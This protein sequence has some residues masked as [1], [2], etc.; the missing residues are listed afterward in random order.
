MFVEPEGATPLDPD[1]MEGLKFKH[2]STRDD[3][4]EIEQANIVQGLRWLALQRG[5]NI[6]KSDF[7]CK[8]HTQLFG[9]I[10]NWAGS[11]RLTEKNIGI[12]PV[13][14]S[15][16]LRQLLDDARY[17]AENNTYAPL[18]A[19]ARFHHRMVQIHPFPNGN[20]RHARISADVYL[21]QYFN[22]API[23]WANGFN[24]QSNNNRRADY[25]AALRTADAGN[26]DLLLEFT[27]AI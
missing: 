21:E 6:L 12:D 1:E 8:I 11:Y 22:H 13:Q 7:V 10:W 23:E 24:L 16:Q 27:E 18:E 17:W 15:I 5:G 14:I 25:L 3:L 9:D 2:I 20:G 19:A 26:F 4:D